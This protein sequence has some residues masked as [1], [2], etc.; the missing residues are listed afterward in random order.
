MLRYDARNSNP[1]FSLP[2]ETGPGAHPA[3]RKLEIGLFLG[4]K[5][6]VTLLW[7][8]T[9]TSA[10]VTSWG[11]ENWKC[12]EYCCYT[13]SPYCSSIFVFFYLQCLCNRSSN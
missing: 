1:H 4:G 12:L 6:A 7:T 5:A 2:F 9:P 13:S 3:S 8:P 10:E 11:K